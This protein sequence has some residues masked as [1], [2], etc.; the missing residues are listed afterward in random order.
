MQAAALI[1]VRLYVAWFCVANNW[2]FTFRNP[3]HDDPTRKL[4]VDWGSWYALGAIGVAALLAF[5]SLVMKN[6]LPLDHRPIEGPKRSKWAIQSLAVYLPLVL[7]FFKLRHTHTTLLLDGRLI[8]T[9][10]GF[11]TDEPWL[12]LIASVLL[13]IA[14]DR[15]GSIWKPRSSSA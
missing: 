8:K 12:L 1:K 14:A 5:S 4:I 15:F 3:W 9:V 7:C 13:M 6:K 11:G 10:R 2:T